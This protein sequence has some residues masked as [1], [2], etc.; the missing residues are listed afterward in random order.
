[1]T[2]K[3]VAK[4]ISDCID[5]IKGQMCSFNKASWGI[6]ERIRIDQNQ[7]VCWTRPD[8]NAEFLFVLDLNKQINNSDSDEY[9]ENILQWL[10]K[11]Q[12]GPETGD[13]VGS[14]PFYFLDGC[15]TDGESGRCLYQNDNG[16]VLYSLL[17]LSRI[18]DDD[19]LL[20]SCKSLADFWVKNQSEKGYFFNPKIPDMHSLAKGPCFVGWMMM[21]MYKIYSIT[22]KQ[23]YLISARKALKYLLDDIILESRIRTSYEL[24]KFEAWRPYSSELA[25]VL[26]ALTIAIKNETDQPLKEQAIIKVKAL[27]NQMEKLQHKTGA[28]VNNDDNLPD[29]LTLQTDKN[30]C[31]LVYTQGFAL[32]ALVEYYQTLKDDKALKMA[33]RLGEFL[34]NIQCKNESPLWDGAWRGAYNVES[35][36]WSGRCTQ[37]NKI[38]E[39]G[40]FSVYTGWCCTNI[41]LG[42][43]SLE[44][45]LND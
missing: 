39:G 25:I 34:V 32:R 35:K 12:N 28:I 38:D 2:K 17:S 31:D 33:K 30:L 40:M 36:C 20:Q 16:K 6:Y 44:K 29:G 8:C 41:M 3:M 23:K 11:K 7:R 9:F 5:W 45:Y 27:L 19:T 42:L 1:M 24:E 14:F 37:N 4:S 22:N 15:F 21:G 26:Y 43:L 18:S 10:L 13:K